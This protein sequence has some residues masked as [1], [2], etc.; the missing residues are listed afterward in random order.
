[1]MSKEVRLWLVD[2]DEVFFF[3]MN[4]I[5]QLE[6]IAAELTCFKNPLSALFK[7][8]ELQHSDL[9]PDL[10]VVDVN[11]PFQ[12]GWEFHQQ[13]QMLQP[14]MK[15]LI[16][17]YMTSALFSDHDHARAKTL[18]SISGVIMKPL[19]AAQVRKMVDGLQP[20]VSTDV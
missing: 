14:N 5:I 3:Y 6:G 17:M 16:R 10:I 1:M 7:L 9:L 8:E 13:L 12:N 20:N 18:S 2:D 19:T 15:K 4:R 11:L